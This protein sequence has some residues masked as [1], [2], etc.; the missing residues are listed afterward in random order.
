MPR[1]FTGIWSSNYPSE[2]KR[3]AWAQG[4]ALGLAHIHKS[5]VVHGDISMDNMLLDR[6]LSIKISGFGYGRILDVDS[7]GLSNNSNSKLSSS[8]P[9]EDNMILI[10]ADIFALGTAIYQIMTGR[11]PFPE[12]DH[13]DPD[14]KQE[15]IKRLKAGKY[16]AMDSMVAGGS[17]AYKC[18]AG[19]YESG[20]EVD[21]DL[22]MCVEAVWGNSFGY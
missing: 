17:V 3:L 20:D 15:M 6:N 9:N 4:A 22:E 16:P 2:T 14:D 11:T 10:K 21:K 5:G 19:S 12:L 7:S 1:P 13:T 18:W 8:S